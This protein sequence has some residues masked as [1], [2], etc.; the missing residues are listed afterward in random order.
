MTHDH[1]R[2]IFLARLLKIPPALLGLD[3]RLIV[4]EDHHGGYN[5]SLPRMAEY[6]EEDAYYAYEDILV[7]GHE[8]IHNGGSLTIA[9]RVERRLRKLIG[10]TKNARATDEEAWQMLLCRFY[11]LST[12]IR[13]QCLLDEATALKHAAQAI[14]LATGLQ[15]VELMAS[16]FVNSAC[17]NTQQ[18]KLQEARKDIT[19]AL[20]YVDRVRNGPLK[21]NIYLEAA[22]I[23]APFAA[24]NRSLQNQCRAWQ[25]KAANL[26][27]KGA[28]E[29]DESFF[30]FNL[31]AVHHEKARVLLTWQK[32]KEER[33][34]ARSKLAMAL[35]TLTPDL[36][37]WKAYYYMTE[38]RLNLADHD[39]EGS[40]QSGKEALKIAKTMHSRIEEENV[41][42]LYH[43]L[44]RLASSNP[45][46]DNLGVELGV[47]A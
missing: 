35:E 32:T 25:D 13:Q 7:M 5:D 20:E 3:W 22:N 42:K 6:L 34:A 24:N 29:P 27:Y 23:H 33:N 46:I 4:F 28:I 15:D 8:Y 47:F 2:R 9:H 40:A 26:L 43:E 30:H 39:L 17:T 10:I 18:G 37:V 19:A 21:G 31:S 11:Q 14:E 36:N 44:T 41:R 16:A 38:A 45:Y 12:R 1:E